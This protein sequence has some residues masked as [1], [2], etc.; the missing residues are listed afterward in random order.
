MENMALYTRLMK[1]GHFQTD[2]AEEDTSAHGD[3]TTLP[4][5]HPAL[6]AA[7]W[8]KFQPSVQNLLPLAPTTYAPEPLTAEDFVTAGAFLGGAAN[9]TGKIT[10]DLV[11]YMNRILKIT[12]RHGDLERQCDGP[13][14]QGSGLLDWQRRDTPADLDSNGDGTPDKDPAY[15][16][17]D[18]CSV[19]P[20]TSDLPRYL[21]PQP[22]RRSSSTSTLRP[23]CATTT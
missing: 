21:V 3:P 19:V 23:I 4:Q 5:L 11:Q 16:T 9:K 10:V 8:A 15:L 1:Y 17:P 20:A 18:K 22:F 12:R 13:A 2:P 14:G 7:D 6:E